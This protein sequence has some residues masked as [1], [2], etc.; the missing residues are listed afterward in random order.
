MN[1]LWPTLIILSLICSFFTSSPG[2]TAAAGLNAAEAAVK[3]VL[4]FA[5]IMCFWSG[6]LRIAENSGMLSKLERLLSPVTG[7]LFPRLKKGSRPLRKITSNIAANM[8]GMGNA[9]TPAGIDAMAELDKINPHPEKPSDEM[10]IFTVLNTASIQLIPT[11]VISLR[12]AAGSSDPPAIIIPVLICSCISL[13]AALFSM[14]LTLH[15]ERRKNK[16][17]RSKT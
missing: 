12:A 13:T 9:A 10:C 11:T 2:E 7:F 3:T 8:L 17:Q 16:N 6:I 4:S 5:G 14:K 1:Y 15:L